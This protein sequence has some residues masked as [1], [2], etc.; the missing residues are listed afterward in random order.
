VIAT[1]VLLAGTGLAACS[2]DVV[3][4]QSLCTVY[5]EYLDG[6]AEIEALDPESLSAAAA[7]DLAD[8]FVL[9]VQRVQHATEDDRNNNGL[10]VLEAAARDLV[11]TLAAIPDDAD[12]ETW[13][14]LV[15]DDLEAVRN[16]AVTVDHA[17]EAECPEAGELG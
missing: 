10:L 7:E 8:D 14:P 9:S 16:A 3:K 13:A 12:F 5:G 2:D 4:D 15:E 1:A 6:L 11:R 17:L